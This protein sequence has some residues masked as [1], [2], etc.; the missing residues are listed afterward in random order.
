M[1][2]I[3]V[4]KVKSSGCLPR[5]RYVIRL[6]MTCVCFSMTEDAFSLCMSNEHL[7]DQSHHS[8][9]QYVKVIAS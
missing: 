6:L 1:R 8:R 4:S 9:F 7:Q 2:N 5:L 3:T